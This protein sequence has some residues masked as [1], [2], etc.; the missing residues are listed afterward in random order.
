MTEDTSKMLALCI[1]KHAKG[2]FFKCVEHWGHEDVSLRALPLGTY[3]VKLG[4]DLLEY[5]SPMVVD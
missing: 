2:L 4:M 3:D 5:H 1:Y